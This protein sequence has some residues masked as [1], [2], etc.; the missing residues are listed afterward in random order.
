MFEVS[1][2]KRILI[3]DY[4]YDGTSIGEAWCDLEIRP[5]STEKTVVIATEVLHNPGPTITNAVCYLAAVVCEDFKIYPSRL[6]WIEHY[7]VWSPAF[8]LSITYTQVQFGVVRP[9]TNR[10]F[11]EPRWQ[12]MTNDG[13]RALGLRPRRASP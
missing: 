1:W 8:G 13:W 5:V 9:G 11:R 2:C 12:P 7:R 4:R 10:T 3:E 6:V